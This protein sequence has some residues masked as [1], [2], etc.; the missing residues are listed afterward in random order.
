MFVR[1]SNWKM[2]MIKYRTTSRRQ[3]EATWLKLLPFQLASSPGLIFRVHNERMDRRT[4]KRPGI[5]CRGS[6]AH[7]L[8]WNVM[9]KMC[10]RSERTESAVTRAKL[11]LLQHCFHSVE[12]SFEVVHKGSNCKHN[13]FAIR[14]QEATQRDLGFDRDNTELRSARAEYQIISIERHIVR[15]YGTASWNTISRL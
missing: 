6:C 7:A 12:K 1:K 4:K 2:L 15:A 10:D 11:Q 13:R 14:S 5:Y 9:G 3:R 8:A